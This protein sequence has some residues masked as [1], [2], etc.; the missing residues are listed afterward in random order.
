MDVKL[1]K[2]KV[3]D[4]KNTLVIMDYHIM[5]YILA[6]DLHDARTRYLN[7]NPINLF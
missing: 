5:S 1:S 4:I 6:I 2:D 3:R 7:P